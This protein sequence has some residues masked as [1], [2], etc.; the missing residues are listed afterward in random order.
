MSAMAETATKGSVF[1][2]QDVRDDRVLTYF[3][4]LQG[5]TKTFR[6]MLMAAYQ[7]RF[8][9]PMVQCEAM[10]DHTINARMPGGWVEVEEGK[11]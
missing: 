1:T 8:Y 4:L 3:D 9:L 5:E 7:G 10:Y 6:I 11:K 2:Y